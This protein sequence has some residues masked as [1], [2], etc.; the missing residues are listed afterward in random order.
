MPNSVERQRGWRAIASVRDFA[1]ARLIESQIHASSFGKDE[2]LC[3]VRRVCANLRLN[4]A[5]QTEAAFLCDEL[6]SRN[7]IIEDIEEERKKRAT[8]FKQMLHEKYEALNDKQFNAVV[9]CRRCGGSEIVFDEKQTRSADES[10]T[11]FC[12]CSKCG[13]RWVVR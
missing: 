11:I 3:G 1:T 12:A 8:I 9:K 6:V 13:L 10:A 2:Y 4:G 5:V 7:T